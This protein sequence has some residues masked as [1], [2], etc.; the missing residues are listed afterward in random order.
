MTRKEDV[1]EQLLLSYSN[2]YTIEQDAPAEPFDAEAVFS[3]HGEQYFLIR[4]VKMSEMNSNEFVFFSVTDTLTE[5]LLKKLDERAWELGLSRTK[6]QAGHRNTDT[7]LL[8]IA[9]AIEPEAAKQI[10][11]IRHY[12]S[13]KF[14]FWGWSGYK[15][16]ALEC[17]SNKTYTNYNGRGLEKIFSV[18]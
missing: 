9:D 15:L 1:L 4:S 7:V 12:Q 16:A 2:Y 11:K 8:I 6:P 14:G 10:Q 18:K 13:Y 5:G 3:V 17:S